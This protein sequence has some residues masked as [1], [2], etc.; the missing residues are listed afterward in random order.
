M[1]QRSKYRTL[2]QNFNFNLKK[3]SSKKSFERR[4]FES[5]DENSL[6]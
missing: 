2:D 3:G 1:A 4:A 6:S 5:V